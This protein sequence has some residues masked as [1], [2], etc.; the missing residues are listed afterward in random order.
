MSLIM[1]YCIMK[2][3][4][5]IMSEHKVKLVDFNEERDRLDTFFSE[6]F[7][8]RKQYESLL[9]VCKIMYNTFTWTK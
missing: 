7:H 5:E 1:L 8:G 9:K 4:Q 3:S 2:S 6:F